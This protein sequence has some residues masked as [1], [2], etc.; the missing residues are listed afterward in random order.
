V[1]NDVFIELAQ[2]LPIYNVNI[3][4]PPPPPPPIFNDKFEIIG[5]DSILHKKEIIKYN[6]KVEQRKQ[7]NIDT[8]FLVVAISDTMIVNED[9]SYEFKPIRFK[10]E[11]YDSLVS[12]YKTGNKG[13]RKI[14]LDK[15]NKF[16]RYKLMFSSELSRG[17]PFTEYPFEFGGIMQFSRIY[18]NAE[19]NKAIF[20]CSYFC[21]R[22]CGSGNMVYL[23]KSSNKWII[24][25]IQMLWVS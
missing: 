11:E 9:Y 17:K 16:Y 14:E 13:K 22:D 7:R 10:G 23:K 18:F 1:I 3:V 19:N 12:I 2:E 25:G 8:S 15:L 24:D 20:Y 4:I 6:E 5:Y 21:G